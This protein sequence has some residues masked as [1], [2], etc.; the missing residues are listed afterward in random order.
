MNL[1]TGESIKKVKAWGLHP[2][3][4]NNGLDRVG[5]GLRIWRSMQFGCEGRM[6]WIGLFTQGFA[7]HNLDGREPSKGCF[8]VHAKRGALKTPAWLRVREGLLES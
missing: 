8:L 7:F 2:W 6:Q 1:H 5:M 4:D 3:I